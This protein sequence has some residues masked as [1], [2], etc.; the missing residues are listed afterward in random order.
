MERYSM[1]TKS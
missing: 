1:S